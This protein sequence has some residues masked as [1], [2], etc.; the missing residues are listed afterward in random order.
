MKK[1]DDTASAYCD[2]CEMTYEVNEN[3]TISEHLKSVEHKN[4]IDRK[5]SAANSGKANS[6]MDHLN[7]FEHKIKVE[8]NQNQNKLLNIEKIKPDPDD[9][10]FIDE[11]NVIRIKEEPQ[12]D[13]SFS[14]ELTENDP[15]DIRS[16]I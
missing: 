8:K 6:E 7:S 3:C 2:F 5:N 9:D 15:L 14:C 11:N 4:S 10:S 1:K 16:E 12:L 13:A